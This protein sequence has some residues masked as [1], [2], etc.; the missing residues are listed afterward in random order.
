MPRSRPPYPSELRRQMVEPV[1]AGRNPDELAREFDPSSQTIRNWVTQ[2]D[3]D[4]GRRDDGLTTLERE[5]R[6]RRRREN[7]RLRE[8]REIP[9][10]ATAQ[11][12]L[13]RPTRGSLRV[14]ERE[15][16]PLPRC[17]DVPD[18]RRLPE[19]VLRVARA[20]AVG[21]LEV[22]PG[23]EGAHPGHPRLEPGHLG[24]TSHPGRARR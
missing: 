14:H 2:A 1:R 20:R 21:P 3:C 23:A 17:Y 22:R 19:R 8:E 12:S 18:A 7:R 15:S 4:E 9:A 5:E 11:V 16:G 24:S 6:R 10:K 13:G